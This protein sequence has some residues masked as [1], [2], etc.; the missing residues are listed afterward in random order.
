M[1]TEVQIHGVGGRY[2]HALFA[3]ASKDNKTEAVAA[4]LAEFDNLANNSKLN[5]VVHDPFISRERRQNILTDVLTK[6]G[7][8]DMITRTFQVMA[9]NNRVSQ[10][11][12]V[13]N[14]YAE[15]LNSQSG[16]VEMTVTTAT[17]LTYQNRALLQKSITQAFLGGDKS[18]KVTEK[19]DASIEGG[20]LVEFGDMVIDAT[21]GRR[22]QAVRRAI[23]NVLD[24]VSSVD[25]GLPDLAGSFPFT[26]VRNFK[27]NAEAIDADAGANIGVPAK[28]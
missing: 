8:S 17:P 14:A 25:V 23:N 4:E 6:A 5:R 21:S 2:A 19:V 28:Y 12:D 22:E 18:V 26:L 13:M 15:I 24:D 3:A 11:K 1:S 7:F 9:E 27:E 10:Y 20:F 16:I